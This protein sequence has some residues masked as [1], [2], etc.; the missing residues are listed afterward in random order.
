MRIYEVRISKAALRDMQELRAF[1]K[2]L[3]S[4]GGVYSL[5]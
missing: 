2:G 5:C 1:L 4:E 3:M